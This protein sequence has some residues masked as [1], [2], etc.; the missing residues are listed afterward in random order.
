SQTQFLEKLR[1]ALRGNRSQRGLADIAAM[2]YVDI[3][4]AST[5]VNYNDS[6]TLRSIVPDIE[7]ELKS[8]LFNPASPFPNENKVD[9]RLM[10]D[11]LT[12]LFRLNPRKT[13]ESLIPLCLQDS[14]PSAF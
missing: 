11:C 7:V 13:Q 6:S 5:Y 14:A 8:K 12:A 2:C 3:C 1:N 4:K 10:T 9:H